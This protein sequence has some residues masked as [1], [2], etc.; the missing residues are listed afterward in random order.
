VPATDDDSPRVAVMGIESELAVLVDGERVAPE[1]LWGSAS[2][3]MGP[4]PLEPSGNA[5]SLPGGSVLYFD[6]GVVEIVTP[7]I[8]LGPAAAARAVRNLWE[9]IGFVRDRLSAWS[10]AHFR[11]VRLQGFSTH[12]NVTFDRPR[13]ADPARTVEKLAVLLAHVLPI[14]V[15]LMGSNRRSTGVGVRPRGNRIEV[16]ADF[17]PD[18]ALMV[19]TAT[20]V[21]GVTRGAMA[22]PSYELDVLQEMRLPTVEGVVP[23]P[24]SSRRGWLVRDY[25]FPRSPF[26]TNVDARV[27]PTR[28]GRLLSLRAIARETAWRFR[29]SLRHHADPFTFRLLFAVLQGRS[30]SLLELPDRPAAYDD[31]GQ[32]I[33]W[34]EVLPPLQARAANGHWDVV[35]DAL[36]NAGTFEAHVS[37]RAK[38]RERALRRG[39]REARRAGAARIRSAVSPPLATGAG[40]GRP[41]RPA[42]PPSD[43]YRGPSRRRDPPYAA[44]WDVAPDEDRRVRPGLLERRFREASVM[45]APFPDRDLTRS[46]YE[47]VFLRLARGTPVRVED[48]V[49]RPARMRG[50]SHAVFVHA[51]TGEERQFSIDELRADGVAWLE[52]KDRT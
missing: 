2:A 32:A 12:Y 27:W 11:P 30:P 16:T 45:A 39:A 23:G 24:H 6:E 15:A 14:P 38:A 48:G 31:V 41:P 9:G 22:L 4:S 13:P 35:V 47:E 40:G 1:R 43:P 44:G 8:E 37:A 29:R 7:V 20:L 34:G 3:L 50:W 42:S 17:T 52:P 19:A 51:D 25:H 21:A 46:G 26:T 36:W 28:D 33:R 10:A 49:Y 5:I 18:P